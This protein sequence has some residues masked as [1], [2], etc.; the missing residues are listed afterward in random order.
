[1]FVWVC[2]DKRARFVHRFLIAVT[3]YKLFLVIFIDIFDQYSSLIS[4]VFTY[5][6]FLI[7]GMFLMHIE[8]Y[9]RG[10]ARFVSYLNRMPLLIVI[11][12][13][14]TGST[15]HV[16]RISAVSYAC[17]FKIFINKFE[18][19]SSADLHPLTVFIPFDHR[20]CHV[21]DK[22]VSRQIGYIAC[23]IGQSYIDHILVIRIDIECTIIFSKS[24]RCKFCFGHS[25]ICRQIFDL[26]RFSA[27]VICGDRN[28]LCFI[29]EQTKNSR[30]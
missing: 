28:F 8:V 19:F 29:E 1:M 17:A 11:R 21:N 3:G 22:A 16:A 25:C 24:R 14:I 4:T 23:L 15:P 12:I 26:Y 5:S 7:K 30:I 13:Q 27:V 9:R 2:S 18:F 10:V 20:R 6:G